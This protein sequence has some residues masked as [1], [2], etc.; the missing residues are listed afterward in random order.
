MFA[1]VCVCV[2]VALFAVCC[3]YCMFQRVFL[4]VFVCLYVFSSHCGGVFPIR[5]Y[6]VCVVFSCLLI[7]IPVFAV[8]FFLCIVVVI[9][10]IIVFLLC[11]KHFARIRMGSVDVAWSSY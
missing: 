1:C 2:C 8:A 6:D 5:F 3:L 4:Y 7:V 9:V 10:F 11:S